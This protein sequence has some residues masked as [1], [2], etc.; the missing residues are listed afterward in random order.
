VIHTI[1]WTGGPKQL[2]AAKA[3]HT[4]GDACIFDPITGKFI[5]TIKSKADRIYVADVAG[6]WREEIILLIGNELHIH[7]NAAAN[8]QPKRQRLWHQQSYRRAK[9][10]HNYYSP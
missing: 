8:P 6:D 3:R 10:T 9:M 1:D 5:H 4:S 7:Q 2:A